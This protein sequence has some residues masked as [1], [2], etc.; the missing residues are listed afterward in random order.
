MY[1]LL[2]LWDEFT[3]TFP[4]LTLPLVHVA[5]GQEL[6]GEVKDEQGQ[7]IGAVEYAGSEFNRDLEQEDSMAS[8]MPLTM[9]PASPAVW[10]LHEATPGVCVCVCVCV[11]I[12]NPIPLTLSPS[13][14]LSC[15]HAGSAAG[16]NP[17]D[18]SMANST[19]APG[20]WVCVCVFTSFL[21]YQDNILSQL[22]RTKFAQEYVAQVHGTSHWSSHSV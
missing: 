12:T 4:G 3:D 14:L 19:P 22:H 15:T 20:V 16:Q 9:S 7:P 8:P 2:V 11:I 5:A 21:A 13:I 6:F 17:S 1:R 18:W 10:S